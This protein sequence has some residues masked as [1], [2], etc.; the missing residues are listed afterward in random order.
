MGLG[1]RSL[2][3]SVYVIITFSLFVVEM[4]CWG[5]RTS[6]LKHKRCIRWIVDRTPSDLVLKLLQ[7]VQRTLDRSKTGKFTKAGKTQIRRMVEGWRKLRW[8]DLIDVLL[9][10]TEVGNSLW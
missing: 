1:C 4:S 9:R 2:G 6:N 8:T 10:L 5:L 7:L 3:Y